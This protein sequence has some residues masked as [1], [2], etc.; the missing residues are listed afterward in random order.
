MA[1]SIIVSELSCTCARFAEDIRHI[2]NDYRAGGLRVLPI[3]SVGGIQNIKDLLFLRGIDM[4]IVHQDNLY[5]LKRTDPTLYANI[6]NRVQYI[7]KL[8]NAEVHIIGRKDIHSLADLEGQT[9]S[10][11]IENSPAATTAE[12]IFD[13][14]KIKVKRVY[15]DHQFALEKLG[16]GEL[17]AHVVMTGAPQPAILKLKPETGFHFLA[18]D[19]DALPNHPGV[20]QLMAEYLPAEL[21]HDLYPNMVP[22]GQSV[23]TIANRAVLAVYAWPEN[24]ER[25]NRIVRFVNEFFSQFDRFHDTSRHPKWKEVNLA[26]EVP[27]WIRF[28]PAKDWL[29]GR[30]PQVSAEAPAE[31][32]ESKAAFETFL[33]RYTAA[34]GKAISPKD[35]D[36]LLVEFKHF[37]D[38]RSTKSTQR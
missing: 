12:N 26:A 11:H 25:H 17:A 10:F 35:R 29:E 9:V 8:Y 37:L 4:A 23:P 38:K 21:T 31:D 20:K 2:V 33:T 22:S 16:S 27:G 24:S 30:K 1:V 32:G 3:L 7:S 34:T 28:K 18:I 36:A 14:L 5:Q 6:E 13:T 19:E 15:Y